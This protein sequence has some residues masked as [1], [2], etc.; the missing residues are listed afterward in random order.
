MSDPSC[1]GDVC[2]EAKAVSR[3]QPEM[4]DEGRKTPFRTS[5]VGKK[6]SAGAL[7]HALREIN[8]QSDIQTEIEFVGRGAFRKVLS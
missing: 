5:V 8:K 6:N 2:T 3:K 7:D 1:E 4:P